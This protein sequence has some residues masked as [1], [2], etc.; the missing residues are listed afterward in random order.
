LGANPEKVAALIADNPV[1][2]RRHYSILLTEDLRETAN[3]RAAA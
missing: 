3:M 2:M 1:T